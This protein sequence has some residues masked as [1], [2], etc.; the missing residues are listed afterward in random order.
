MEFLL[1]IGSNATSARPTK[2]MKKTKRGER[3]ETYANFTKRHCLVMA[4]KENVRGR[5]GNGRIYHEGREALYRELA[6]MEGLP[7]DVADKMDHT[8]V[9]DL[10]VAFG[11]SHRHS[12]S[13]NWKAG[14]SDELVSSVTNL[15]S[16]LTG[17]APEPGM[18]SA[19]LERLP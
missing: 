12:K 18:L 11:R 5:V 19:I 16:A 15:Y 10:I 9:V 8:D 17:R 3:T 2:R 6:E 14:A 13:V 4:D 7:E 1:T